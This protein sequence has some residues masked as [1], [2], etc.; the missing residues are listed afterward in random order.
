MKFQNLKELV[1]Y[2]ARENS[3]KNFITSPED[4][5]QLTFLAFK[6]E[7]DTL[8][9]ALQ[10]N[11]LSR[12]D[13]VA[14]VLGNGISA[15]VAF[16][17]VAN[18]GGIAVPVNP[19]LK[20]QEVAY[21]LENSESRYILTS[22][23]LAPGLAPQVAA[24][25]LGGEL[26]LLEL[27][28][29]R[30]PA[31]VGDLGPESLALLLYTSG[32]TGHPKGVQLSQRNL[33]V[34]AVQITEAHRLDEDDS[35]LCVL[36][37]YHINGLVVTLIAPLYSGG[38]VIMP[39]KFSAGGFWDWVVKYGVTWFSAVPT[40]LSILLSGPVKSALDLSRLRFARSASAALPEAVLEK[41]ES[42][43]GVPVIESY[44]ISEGASQITSNPL[45]PKKRK[46][47]SVGLPWGN[48]IR[49][50]DQKGEPLP[51]YVS[52]EVILRGGNI[53]SGYYKNPEATRE[54]FSGGWF[55]TGDLGYL[56][57]EG[58]LFLSGRIKELINRAGEKFSP[59]EIDEVLYLI[60]EV[61]LAACVGI[62]DDL[63]GEEVGAFVKLRPGANLSAEQLIDF[64]AQRLADF[65]VPKR[66]NFI[67]DFPKGPS[68]KIQRLKL[69][70]TYQQVRGSVV[71]D[72]AACKECGY[73][74]LVCP[75]NVFKRG[76]RFNEKGYRSYEVVSP[77]KCSGCRKCFF[78][79]PDFA[80]EI[81]GER[82]IR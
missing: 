10:K 55:H 57:D 61:E 8:S 77:E 2:R 21:L 9:A 69:A 7:V 34:E 72:H 18:G 25:R 63:Y 67:A 13:K 46:S 70:E 51:P 75:Q 31:H 80:I 42:R 14:I 30:G 33:L 11:G 16:F 49:V 47:G 81:T 39:G 17:G 54:A 73:C 58:Y 59:R 45:P 29:G 60:P 76:E 44:G 74:Q 41:F 53:S 4:N 5:R 43:F 3:G 50:V 32:T 40:I 36:P 71:I 79:C 52:G 15:A 19:G 6:Q 35:A 82:K 22:D 24:S 12:G 78:A 56:D 27:A 28:G 1:D 37:L 65:K 23:V 38:Q 68:G 66:V 62:P 20:Q 64:C 48:E 26:V